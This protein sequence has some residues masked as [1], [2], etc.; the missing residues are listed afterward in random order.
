MIDRTG[1]VLAFMPMFR[2]GLFANGYMVPICW[3][4]SIG[5]EYRRKLK[6]S[7]RADRSIEKGKDLRELWAVY[8]AQNTYMSVV[9]ADSFLAEAEK[10]RAKWRSQD[11]CI[12]AHSALDKLLDLFLGNPELSPC[13]PPK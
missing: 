1:L 7:S 8:N 11:L 4:A 6:D 13:V 2:R 5:R 9:V 12:P 10:L 3:G